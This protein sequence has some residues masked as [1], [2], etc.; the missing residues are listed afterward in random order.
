MT[1]FQLK[2]ITSYNLHFWNTTVFEFHVDLKTSELFNYY[3][4]QIC[5]KL[6][7][8][9]TCITWYSHQK[10]VLCILFSDKSF[11]SSEQIFFFNNKSYQTTEIQSNVKSWPFYPFEAFEWNDVHWSPSKGMSVPRKHCSL[12]I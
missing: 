4:E 9:L 5:W 12:V 1:S 2:Y 7:P 11:F 6:L 8:L 3:Y 10:L